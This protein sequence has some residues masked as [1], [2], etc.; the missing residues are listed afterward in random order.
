MKKFYTVLETAEIYGVNRS[1]VHNWITK[2]FITPIRVAC[3][4]TPGYQYMIPE[5]FMRYAKAY[6]EF[7]DLRRVRNVAKALLDAA[8]E[9]EESRYRD[10]CWMQEFGDKIYKEGLGD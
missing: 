3:E 4:H 9:I 2:G 8:D 1:V 5:E 7:R 10:L 6:R